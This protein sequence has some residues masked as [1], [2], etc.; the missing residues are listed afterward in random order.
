MLNFSKA[1]MHSKK[2]PTPHTLAQRCQHSLPLAQ[3][4]PTPDDVSNLSHHL[5]L[6]SA[7][8]KG[9]RVQLP[10]PPHPPYKAGHLVWRCESFWT[11]NPPENISD[12]NVFACVY[13]FFYHVYFIPQRVVIQDPFWTIVCIFFMFFCTLMSSSSLS[14]V[15]QPKPKAGDAHNQYNTKDGTKNKVPLT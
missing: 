7:L 15:Q 14:V 2:I 5:L 6:A 4:W 9:G 10:L 1:A 12:S 3:G 11:W 13:L 8:S